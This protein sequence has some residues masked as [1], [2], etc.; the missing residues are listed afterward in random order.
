MAVTRK[1]QANKLGVNVDIARNEHVEFKV[2]FKGAQ[3]LFA[4]VDEHDDVLL[5]PKDEPDSP[6]HWTT[7]W[8]R[9][10]SNH[11]AGTEVEVAF[12]AQF[13]AATEYSYQVTVRASDGS[14]RATA[15]D[16]T[17]SCEDPKRSVYSSLTLRV[18]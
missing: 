12:G 4:V 11:T 6:G 3:P 7:T 17:Y 2:A 15:K 5:S 14:V 13:L 18:V 10:D 16:C 8:P 9:E 1:C